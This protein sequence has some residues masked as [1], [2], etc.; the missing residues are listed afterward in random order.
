MSY[1]WIEKRMEPRYLSKRQ[2]GGG[3][4]MFWGSFSYHWGINMVVMNG[5]LAVEHYIDI[6]D[7]YFANKSKEIHSEGYACQQDNATP[8]TAK[9]TQKWLMDQKITV[10]D[11]SVRSLNLNRVEHLCGDLS[12]RIYKNFKQHDTLQELIE[13]VADTW[14][15]SMKNAAKILQY[16]SSTVLYRLLS[17]ALGKLVTK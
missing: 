11:C 12:M 5:I 15:K 10:M 7:A 17:M 3:S 13:G 2:N 16:H 4:F 1:L 9:A 6:I 14:E 8:H